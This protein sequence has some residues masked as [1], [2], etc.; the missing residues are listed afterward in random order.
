M[1]RERRDHLLSV[2]AALALQY[3]EL[4]AL[5]ESFAASTVHN[6]P[7]RVQILSVMN[8]PGPA[9]HLGIQNVIGSLWS[10]LLV[11]IL[12]P[13]RTQELFFKKAR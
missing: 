10:D 5:S 1:L 4:E 8:C 12:L 2:F 6:S 13:C 3:F 9:P 7:A 11:E